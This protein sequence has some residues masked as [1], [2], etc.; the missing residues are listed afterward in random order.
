[1]PL[2][3]H[4]GH[5]G[6][7]LVPQGATFRDRHRH[8]LPHLAWDLARSHHHRTPRRA[9][10]GLRCRWSTP[11]SLETG[12]PRRRTPSWA[13]APS[14]GASRWA[15]RWRRGRSRTGTSPR[16]SASRPPPARPR[17]AGPSR[18]RTACWS[19]ARGSARPCTPGGASRSSCAPPAARRRPRCSPRPPPRRPSARGRLVTAP[20]CR[21]SPHSRSMRGSSNSLSSAAL[22]IREPMSV[23]GLDL[24]T[25]SAASMVAA[26]SSMG[27][28]GR[29]SWTTA[30]RCGATA[31]CS[32]RTPPARGS[33]G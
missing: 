6:P 27:R 8:G 11:R 2:P 13:W 12:G 33:S 28:F 25:M 20:S 17:A 29:W 15:S 19:S 31:A 24:C 14:S 18:T 10:W 32:A 16:T 4:T 21:H 23:M 5:T 22:F 1:M 3:R 30:C 26:S 7:H 9:A